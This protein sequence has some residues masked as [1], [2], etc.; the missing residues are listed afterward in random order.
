MRAPT[1]RAVWTSI[2]ECFFDEDDAAMKRSTSILVVLAAGCA[3]MTAY[4]YVFGLEVKSADGFVIRY[5]G[6]L[7]DELRSV[8]EEHDR[9]A[10]PILQARRT[11]GGPIPVE[12]WLSRSYR[13]KQ[14]LSGGHHTPSKCPGQCSQA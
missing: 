8:L 11:L 4:T 10:Q 12:S 9:I 1:A 7:D 3:I 14:K 5:V 6:A 2:R 13:I